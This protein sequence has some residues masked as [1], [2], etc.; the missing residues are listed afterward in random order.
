MTRPAVR[1][2]LKCLLLVV[3]ILLLLPVLL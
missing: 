3:L 1:F 2:T